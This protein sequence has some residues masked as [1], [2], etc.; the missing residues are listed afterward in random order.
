MLYSFLVTGGWL[1]L[2]R[3]RKLQIMLLVGIEQDNR[4]RKGDRFKRE[5][6]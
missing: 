3:K 5:A 1:A 6:E 2:Y 4:E